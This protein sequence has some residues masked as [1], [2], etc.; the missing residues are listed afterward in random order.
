MSWHDR[1][2]WYHP[3]R[4]SEAIQHRGYR[5]GVRG[6]MGNIDLRLAVDRLGEVCDTAPEAGGVL[7]ALC[8]LLRGL[9]GT[10]DAGLGNRAAD[11]RPA[12]G[13]RPAGS[14]AAAVDPVAPVAAAG[15][16]KLDEALACVRK[17]A[18]HNAA[19]MRAIETAIRDARGRIANR[20]DAREPAE[21]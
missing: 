15:V 17:Y 20:A 16:G 13:D 10:H 12:T 11:V 9:D 4:R 21:A 18:R 7:S 2:F 8:E 5:E 6:V 1:R 3:D 19:D 14:R